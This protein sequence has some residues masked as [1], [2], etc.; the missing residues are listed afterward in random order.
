MFQAFHASGIFMRYLLSGLLLLSA[1]SAQALT[2]DEWQTQQA[3]TPAFQS[4]LERS[5]WLEKTEVRVRASGR[6]LFMP[7]GKLYWQWLTPE[8][9]FHR[10]TAKSR[11]VDQA[12]ATLPETRSL[13]PAAHDEL[14]DERQ[15]S[16]LL[17]DALNGNLAALK[18]RYHL[19]LEGERDEWQLILLPRDREESGPKR[20]LV[21]GGRFLDS[22]QAVSSD[23]D[24]ITLKLSR[25]QRLVDPEGATQLRATLQHRA[26]KEDTGTPADDAITPES[27]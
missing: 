7:R 13:M 14:P 16:Y 20:I 17:F 11:L 19:L 27:A 10:L 5:H 15:M 2:L 6:L 9:A 12:L 1:F 25:H 4:Q 3:A 26:G 22:I 23:G 18:A 21:E 24:T 8:P